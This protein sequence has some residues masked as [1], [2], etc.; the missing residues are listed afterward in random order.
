MGKKIGLVFAG[1]GGKG[2]Y[3]IGVWKALEEFGVA[4]NIKAIAG[5]SV[6]ALN[7]ALFVQ[8]D[9]S[10]A[11]EVWL[12]MSSDRI[13]SLDSNSLIRKIAV[14]LGSNSKILDWL[15]RSKEYGVFSRSGLKEIIRNNIAIEA[16]TSSDISFYAAAC[17]IP[18]FKVDYF[19]LNN[20]NQERFISTLLATSALPII[21]GR[22]K[23]DNKDY[24]D[25]GIKDNTPIKP[26]YEEGCD[27]VF[28]V[29]LSRNL[30][31]PDFIDKDI[32]PG[33][34]IIEIVPQEDLGSLINGTL[35]FTGSGAYRRIEQGYQDTNK[36]LEPIFNMVKSGQKI[37]TILNKLKKDE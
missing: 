25:G 4:D 15:N 22:E 32:Y 26:L 16:V 33:C 37:S 3:Q 35:D 24:L 31:K 23:I 6:G 13:L 2:A 1:G 17:Q 34:Q 28:V 19:K 12:S 10:L 20:C 21:F 29:Y 27:L 7:G 8:G 9:L 11:K 14:N 30:S 5:T 36:I 18:Q